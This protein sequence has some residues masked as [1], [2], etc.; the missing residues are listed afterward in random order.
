MIRRRESTTVGVALSLIAFCVADANAQ[1]STGQSHP[2]ASTGEHVVGDTFEGLIMAPHHAHEWRPTR[3]QV[4]TVEKVLVPYLTPTI[5]VDGR[6]QPLSAE[7]L[8]TYKRL[9]V[10]VENKNGRAIQIY[11]YC[12]L[13]GWPARVVWPRG[14]GACYIQATWNVNAAK[15]VAATANSNS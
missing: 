1:S 4:L 2:S 6:K 12:H 8:A 14:G 15:F 13:K 11:L 9:Y 7:K 3:E 10:G 5:N